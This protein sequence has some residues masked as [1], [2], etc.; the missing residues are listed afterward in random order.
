MQILHGFTAQFAAGIWLLAWPIWSLCVS[1]SSGAI[2]LGWRG[3]RRTDHPA[4]FWALVFAFVCLALFGIAL[5]ATALMRVPFPP[6]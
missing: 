4:M 1:L 5:V 2:P 3:I 6:I